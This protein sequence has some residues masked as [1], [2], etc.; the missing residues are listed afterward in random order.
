MISRRALLSV[1]LSLC[2]SL[3][4][5]TPQLESP[6]GLE[7]AP[8]AADNGPR[9]AVSGTVVNSVTGEPISRAMIQLFVNGSHVTLSGPDGHFQ[10]QS[11]SAGAATI[12][13]QKPG[14]FNVQELN[15][16][17]AG[18][19]YPVLQVGQDSSSNLIVK[20][21]PSAK[22][23]GRVV[24]SS[25]EPIENV[26]IRGLVRRVD[27]GEVR[28]EERG[29]AHTDDSGEYRMANL[30]P[31][32]YVVS[33]GAK[34]ASEFWPVARQAGE[35]SDRFYPP[36]FFPGAAT[37]STAS[38]VSVS[39]G[40]ES[41]ADFRLAVAKT[42][43]VIGTVSGIRP[44][45]SSF[46]LLDA[47]GTLTGLPGFFDSRTNRFRFSG[48]QPGAYTIL[49]NSVHGNTALA[50]VTNVN[51]GNADVENVELTVGAVGSIPVHIEFE[52]AGNS[53]VGQSQNVAVHL[54]PRDPSPFNLGGWSQVQQVNGTTE[55]S[56]PRMIPGKYKAEVQS[57][58]EVYVSSLRAGSSD[59]SRDD[60]VIAPGGD[61]P[62]V[63]VV[64]RG[65]AA[66][67][68]GILKNNDLPVRGWIV[69]LPDGASPSAPIVTAANGAFTVGG[70]APG[71]YHI[72]GFPSVRGL[73]YRNAE[74]MRNYESA[75]TAVSLGENDKKEV[76]VALITG[77]RS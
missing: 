27:N 54:I 38:P 33:T 32:E 9:Y 64:M 60:L 4:A 46:M 20:L 2:F 70:L 42:Y 74:F 5:R 30:M 51:V 41:N 19:P 23:S 6:R 72:Y 14:F 3:A 17:D 36:T 53:T 37:L 71:T 28:W 29:N 68:H 57:S 50:G 61:T 13:A 56:I 48:V 31:G 39:A 24:D 26:Q 77:G 62:S 1:G 73:E 25:G 35:S 67:L 65:G 58:G 15:M 16:G 75:S 18:S 45:P 10:F 47:D 22:I 63:E 59:L 40:Q 49:V 69:V 55:V 12:T 52:N 21:M 44:G 76:S 43:R 66:S 7:R 8:N 34:S 11:V